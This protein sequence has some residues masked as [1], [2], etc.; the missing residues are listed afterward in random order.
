MRYVEAPNE[1]EDTSLA[2][3]VFLAGG[4]TDCEPWQTQMAELLAHTDLTVFNPRRANF[5]ITDVR[6][7]PAQIA[8]EHRYLGRA[9]IKLFWFPP[10]SLC[11]ITLFELG[12]WSM[13]NAPLAVGVHP[14]YRRRLDVFIQLELARLDVLVV[15]RLVDLAEQVQ[16]CAMR[17]PLTAATG[18]KNAPWMQGVNKQI[19]WKADDR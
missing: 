18:P 15:D 2:P 16:K 8:W 17:C 6:A 11:P 7:A 5:P 3:S 9:T 13:T 1:C 19:S 14:D 4:I 10:T 12:A